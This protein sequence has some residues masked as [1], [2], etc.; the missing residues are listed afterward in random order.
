MAGLLQHAQDHELA[1]IRTEQ[2]DRVLSGPIAGSSMTA[3]S[4]VD[5]ARAGM[6]YQASPDRQSWVLVRK[7]EKLMIRVNPRAVDA[8]E[9][10]EIVGL[11]NLR[12]GQLY[13]D[14]V[15]APGDVPD[16]LL[17]P[18][19]PSSELRISPRSTSQVFFYLS[20]GVEVPAAHQQCGL[21]KPTVNA[22]GEPMD[23]RALTRGLFEVHACSGHK[24]PP[25]AYLAVRNRGY[26]YYI[27]DRDQASKSTLS[28][29][30]QL[31]RLDFGTQKATGPILTLPVG[32]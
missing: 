11:L 23:S 8:P 28:L 24:P 31:S 18:R 12:P 32:R 14:V 9:V 22:Q 1:T 19:P 30:L 25:T 27:D 5:A 6:E 10:R 26:W 15:V 29:V 16:P 20:N 7:E 17:Y 3:A 4:L 2:R 21:V 13:Y